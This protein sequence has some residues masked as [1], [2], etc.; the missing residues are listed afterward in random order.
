MNLNTKTST[1]PLPQATDLEQ[2]DRHPP[3]HT[4]SQDIPHAGQ[5]EEGPTHENSPQVLTIVTAPIK[6]RTM[7]T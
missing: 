4:M 2:P 5:L 6:T 7:M 1:W 3:D